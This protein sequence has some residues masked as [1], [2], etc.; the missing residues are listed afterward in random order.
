MRAALDLE[1]WRGIK[2]LGYGSCLCVRVCISC[3]PSFAPPANVVWRRLSMPAKPQS[4]N[5]YV[6]AVYA[7]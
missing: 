1:A 3:I 4:S 7:M 6:T 5:Q 2:S